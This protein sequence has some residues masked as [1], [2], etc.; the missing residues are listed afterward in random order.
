MGVLSGQISCKRNSFNESFDCPDY[1]KPWESSRVEASN[2]SDLA[3]TFPPEQ[4]TAEKDMKRTIFGVGVSERNNDSLPMASRRQGLQTTFG[5][6]SHAAN[7]DSSSISSWMKPSTSLN[8]SLMSVQGEPAFSASTHI[9]KGSISLMQSPQVIRDRLVITSNSRSAPSLKAE[10]S[11]QDDVC[12]ITWSKANESQ[13]SKSSIGLGLSNGIADHSS[14]SEHF[15][16]GPQGQFWALGGLVD[17]KSSKGMNDAVPS[18]R[19]ASEVNFKQNQESPQGGLTW[20]RAMPLCSGR[21]CNEETEVSQTMKTDSLP[22]NSLQFVKQTDLRKGP[23]QC[24]IHDYPAKTHVLDTENKSVETSGCS[25]IKKILGFPIFDST[26]KP[27]CVSSV[28]S[29]GNHVK[30]GSVE[31]DLPCDHV[32]SRSGGEQLKVEGVVVVK[33]LVNGKTD[34]RN[35]IDLNKCM[36]EEEG[37]LTPTSPIAKATTVIDLEAMVDSEMSISHASDSVER[38]KE[39]LDLAVSELGLPSEKLIRAAAEAL[40]AI[41]SSE[42]KDLQ[43]NAAHD[44]QENGACHQSEVS[45]N[46]SLHWFADIIS[47]CNGDNGNE[48]ETRTGK[49]SACDELSIPDGID[50]FEYMTLN[51]TEAEVEGIHYEH[52]KLDNPKEE[53]PLPKRPRRGQARRGRQRK[54]FQRDILPALASLSRNEVTEDIQTIEGIIRATGGTWQSSLASRNAGKGGRGRRRTGCSAPSPPLAAACQPQA[55]QTNSREGGEEDRSLAGWGKRTRRPP[56]LRCSL[57]NSPVSLK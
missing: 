39:P 31:S 41:S 4:N 18:N 51:L 43:D 15:V 42:I 11:C 45:T 32:S 28:S 9:S 16:H 12:N 6:Q 22:V 55:Q 54:D 26:T 40:I 34:L 20:L 29:N 50:F 13:A 52:Q 10:V 36:T 35:L 30:I 23:S 2:A 37:Q 7:S 53:D 5:P 14:A 8:Q 19:Y 44:L 17:P 57:S 38:C 48:N 46:D 56:R 21:S 25:S 1:Q 27:G 47:S 49:V 24:L 3:M 33:G